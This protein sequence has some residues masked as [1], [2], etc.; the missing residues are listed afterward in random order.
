MPSRTFQA[1][2]Q[3]G[4]DPFPYSP[5]DL[6]AMFELDLEK[7]RSIGSRNPGLKATR[8]EWAMECQAQPDPDGALGPASPRVQGH[9]HEL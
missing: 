1:E 9:G 5:E 8:P 7:G 3:G 2:A 6:Q 4:P